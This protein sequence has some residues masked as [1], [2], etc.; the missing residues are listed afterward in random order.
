MPLSSRLDV[1]VSYP[2]VFNVTMEPGLEF[3]TI[4]GPHGVDTEGDALNH[5][6]DKFNRRGLVVMRID[7]QGSDTGGVAQDTVLEPL[8]CPSG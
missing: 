1:S 7:L 4:I 5:V 8:D 6:I 3:V 2:Q